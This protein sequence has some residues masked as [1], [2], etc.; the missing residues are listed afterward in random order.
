MCRDCPGPSRRKSAESET[1]S[2]GCFLRLLGAP[3]RGRQGRSR[4]LL[5]VKL[6]DELFLHRR[7]DLGPLWEAEDLRREAVMVGLEPGR[8][9]GGQLCCFADDGLDRRVRSHRDH[10]LVAQLVRGDVHALAVDRPVSVQDHLACLAP[11]AGEAKPHEY[12]VEARLQ[13]AQQ[14]LA[15]YAGLAARLVVVVAELLLEHAVIAA[16]LLLLAQLDA[17]LRL[18]RA[19]AAVVTRRVRP[20]LDAALVGQ[21]TLALEEQLDA[22]AAAL[23]A[24]R[25]G[26][27]R[28]QTRLLLRGRQPLC[29]CGV[30]SLME[31]ISRP[32]ACSE[33]IAVSRPEPG[34]LTNT[35]T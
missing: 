9:D 25:S 29:A 14:V 30:T 5:R 6:D 2:W 3:S 32:A 1:R 13:Q 33:R 4:S 17:V 23:L 24:L 10:V 7:G 21:A 35:S 20:A 18:A 12:V 15:G 11:G 22:L 27:A 34:P 8:H 28:H 19:A 31:V 16:R 26:V